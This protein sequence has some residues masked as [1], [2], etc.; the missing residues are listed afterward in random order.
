MTLTNCLT[1]GINKVNVY[2]IFRAFWLLKLH[3]ELV[4]REVRTDKYL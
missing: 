3:I 1:E 2:I 4:L